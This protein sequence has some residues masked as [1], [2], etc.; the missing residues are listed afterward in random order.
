M[1]ARRR[2]LAGSAAALGALA[3]AA[4]GARAGGVAA[5]TGVVD[6]RAFGAAGDGTTRDTAAIQ[7]AVDAAA[8]AGGGTVLLG[9]GRFLAGTVTLRTGVSLH[10][11]AG[12]VL[13]GSPD[14]ADYPP[15]ELGARDLD[16]GGRRVWA[17]LYA[18]GA[19]RIGVEGAGVIDGNG[20]F[21]PKV[22]I[23]DPDVASGPRPRTV[24]FRDCRAV[25]LRDVTLRE[26]GMWTV[27]LAH[28]DAVRVQGLRVTST[29][30]LHQDGIVV[31][32]CRDAVVRDCD[33]DTLDD[34]V[35]LKSSFS[36]PCTDVVVSGCVVRSRC[37]GIKLGTQSLGGFRGVTVADCLL[38]DCRLGGLKLQT[39]DGG[40]L[41][42]VTVRDLTMRD[43]AAPLAIRRGARGFDYG[44]TD[45]ARPRPVGR[46]RGVRIERVDATVAPGTPLAGATS[47]VAGLPGLP[48]EDVV[49][50]DVHVTVPGGGSVADAARRDPPEEARAY[51][52]HTMFGVLPASGLWAR[53]AA[54]LTLRGVRIELTGPDARPAVVVDDVEGLA[55]D[56]TDPAG[57]D[58]VDRG[59]R[60]GT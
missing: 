60:G 15:H 36:R 23:R 8:S 11:A 16:V 1:V 49:L 57:I 9:P 2:F 52:E 4:T 3:L 40:D 32:S 35:V 51:P 21:F 25:T 37:A 53:H 42:D 59:V 43:V 14:I 54:R 28:C 31:D 10:L 13:L 18:E 47:S 12:A 29:L 48:V 58:L 38:H 39:V 24:F 17:L 33:V 19:E 50:A 41:E 34:A 45:V 44:A 22:P 55:L 27:H 30:H 56:R 5:A 6:V 20:A 26:S 46:L 7:A